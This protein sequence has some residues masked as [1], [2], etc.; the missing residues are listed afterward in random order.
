[1]TYCASFDYDYID[2]RKHTVKD[3]VFSKRLCSLPFEE[4]AAKY[5]HEYVLAHPNENVNDLHCEIVVEEREEDHY[6][7]GG[8]Y[9]HTFQIYKEREESMNE[10]TER[11]AQDEFKMIDSYMKAL[12]GM[13]SKLN[14]GINCEER[15]HKDLLS[16]LLINN[17]KKIVDEEIT[18]SDE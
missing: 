6:G 10:Y 14:Y 5:F 8:G 13:T 7:N 2:R 4:Y 15:I 1:M 12:K 3:V 16:E 9:D 18:C 17:F 11:V